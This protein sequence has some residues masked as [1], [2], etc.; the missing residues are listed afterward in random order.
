MGYCFFA[1][2]QGFIGRPAHGAL[3]MHPRADDGQP[4]SYKKKPRADL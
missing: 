3:T 2:V 4:N 1:I